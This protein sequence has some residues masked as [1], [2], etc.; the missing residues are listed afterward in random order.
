MLYEFLCGT[1]PFGEDLED[2][3]A[4]YEIVLARKI[5]YPSYFN[6]E[7][8][9]KSVIEQLLSKNPSMRSGG[10]IQNLKKHRWFEGFDWENFEVKKGEVPYIPEIKDFSREFV[11][12]L[13]R[14]ERYQ[15]VFR[16]QESK[17]VIPKNKKMKNKY[18]DRDWDSEF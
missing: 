11:E 8:V 9:A 1:L 14:R 18:S 12:A 13:G 10:G 2:P 5:E 7:S 16:E 3:F 4:I 15:D 17:E 6:Q